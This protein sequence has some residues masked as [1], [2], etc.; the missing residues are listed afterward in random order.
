MQK[1]RVVDDDKELREM[2][3]MA[4][5]GQGYVTT[6]LTNG[7]AFFDSI[8]SFRPDIILQDIFLGD[9]DGRVLCYEMKKQPAYHHIT[10]ILYPAGHVSLSSVERSEAD[11]FVP[12]PFDIKQLI[13]KMKNM[14]RMQTV[15]T[16]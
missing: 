12:K 2:V 5:S 7:R 13:E 6:T 14:L 4:L 8:E 16:F 15:A 11:E 3:D 1:I 9:A 10:V